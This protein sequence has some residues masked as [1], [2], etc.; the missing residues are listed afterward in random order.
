M[1]TLG[2]TFKEHYTNDS[3]DMPGSHIGTAG[4]PGVPLTGALRRPAGAS[5][6]H[7]QDP[8]PLVLSGR[9]S[10]STDGKL[11]VE[12]FELLTAASLALLLWS[13][14]EFAENRLKLAEILYYKILENVMLQETRRLHGKDMSVSSSAAWR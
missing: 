1:K 6:V 9:G 2:Q 11:Q 13:V 8:A 7:R 4:S 12:I 3:E 10:W 14:P 5:G